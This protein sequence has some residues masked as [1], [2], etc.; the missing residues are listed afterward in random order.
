MNKAARDQDAVYQTSKLEG[1]SNLISGHGKSAEAEQ[2]S[3]ERTEKGSIE[4]PVVS[5]SER[6]AAS[7]P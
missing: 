1:E 6:K 4:N 5:R 2:A 3:I 7:E